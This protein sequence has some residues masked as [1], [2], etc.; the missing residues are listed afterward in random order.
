M[1]QDEEIEHYVE[2]IKN[3]NFKNRSSNYKK[4]VKRLEIINDEYKKLCEISNS[5]PKLKKSK[6]SIKELIDELD[7]IDSCIDENKTNMEELIKK[8]IN[9]KIMLND[10]TLELND[11]KNE[12]YR[13]NMKSKKIEL[14]KLN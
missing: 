11:M 14:V 2:K 3:G 7:K 13:V 6:L 4:A 10:M 12:L 5:K 9:K 1:Y 8:Y